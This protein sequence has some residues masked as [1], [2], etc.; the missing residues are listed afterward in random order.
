MT[1][2]NGKGNIL[3]KVKGMEL[4]SAKTNQRQIVSYAVVDFD[5]TSQIQR[6]IRRLFDL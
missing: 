1:R 5:D 6:A 4:F 3:K 2:Q